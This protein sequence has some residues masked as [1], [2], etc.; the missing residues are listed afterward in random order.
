M[1]EYPWWIF[2]HSRDEILPPQ[3][4]RSLWVAQ[5]WGSYSV[6]S[7]IR[8]LVGIEWIRRLVQ[9]PIS[10]ATHVILFYSPE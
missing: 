1:G 9:N 5:L 6:L 7:S 8:A 3:Y 2:P 4:A 10:A